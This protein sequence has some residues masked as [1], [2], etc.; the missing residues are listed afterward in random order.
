MPIIVK[1]K[2][3]YTPAP[4]GTPAAVCIDVVDLGELKVEFG[5]EAKMRHKVRIVWQ[6][7]AYREDG[8]PFYV[9]KRY[10]HSLHEKASLRKDLESWLGRALTAQ[11]LEGFDLESLLS[12]ACL[13]NIIHENKNGQTYANVASI[14]PLPK[15]MAAPSPRD[16][17]RVCDREP[18]EAPPVDEP[19]D[20][21][22]SDEDVPC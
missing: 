2:A 3:N 1:A 20:S 17:V 9:S 22:I 13:L 12:S 18:T 10:T 6:I 11:E 4:A 14:M 15:S 19:P 5:G 21:V 7:D 16:Y 8:K